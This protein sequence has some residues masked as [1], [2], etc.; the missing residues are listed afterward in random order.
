L[1]VVEKS[2]LRMIF[3]RLMLARSCSPTFGSAPEPTENDSLSLEKIG[4]AAEWGQEFW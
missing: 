2:L 4:R 3:Q 1:L